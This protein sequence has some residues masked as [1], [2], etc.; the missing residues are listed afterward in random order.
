MCLGVSGEGEDDPVY[1]HFEFEN[2]KP[3][4]IP[5]INN[6]FSLRKMCPPG[7]IL[8]FYTVNDS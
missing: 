4:Y 7:R 6:R 8:Y 5:K 1:I 2:Y 3:I